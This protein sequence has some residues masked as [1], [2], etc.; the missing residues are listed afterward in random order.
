MA[1][2]LPRTA[3][4][5]LLPPT[6]VPGAGV[7]VSEESFALATVLARRGAELS[8]GERVRTLHG[9][10]LPSRPGVVTGNGVSF[11]ATAPGA[12][13]ALSAEAGEDFAANLAN[14]LSGLASVADQ[15]D[16]YAVLRLSGPHVRDVLAKGF[17]IDL[18]PNVFG[19]G[20]AAVTAAAHIGAILWRMPAD[21]DETAT[22]HVA[23]FRSYAGSFSHWLAASAAEYGIAAA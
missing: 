18:H 23:V 17:T 20:A 8:L 4:A 16:G 3:Y 2:L 6:P 7:A 15:S 12:W 1:E 19:P 5:G 11:I 22:F 14:S 10:D 9:L 21:E 13:L